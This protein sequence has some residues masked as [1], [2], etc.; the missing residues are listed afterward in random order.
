MKLTE[1]IRKSAAEQGLVEDEAVKN[2]WKKGATSLRSRETRI[3]PP[4]PP[5]KLQP[6]KAIMPE[7]QIVTRQSNPVS[8]IIGY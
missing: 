4:H 2:A 1:D 3:A 8:V 7:P 5:D 6:V